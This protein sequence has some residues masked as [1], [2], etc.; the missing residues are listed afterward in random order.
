[1]ISMMNWLPDKVGGR[2]QAGGRE[3]LRGQEMLLSRGYNI[4]AWDSRLGLKTVPSIMF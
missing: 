3:L 4:T 2:Q 1:M